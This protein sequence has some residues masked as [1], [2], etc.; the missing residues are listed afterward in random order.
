MSKLVGSVLKVCGMCRKCRN[1]NIGG[2]GILSD[3]TST[4][5]SNRGNFNSNM[6]DVSVTKVLL[7]LTSSRTSY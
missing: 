5:T 7:P 2:M 3:T 6:N 1:D 4:G